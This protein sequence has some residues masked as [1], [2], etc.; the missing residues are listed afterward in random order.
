MKT[1]P[2]ESSVMLAG[3]TRGLWI[4]APTDRHVQTRALVPATAG[5]R[6]LQSADAA[7]SG[8]AHDDVGHGLAGTTSHRNR[9]GR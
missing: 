1:R 7:P 5:R 9:D 2:L 4:G 3:L 8:D 6:S